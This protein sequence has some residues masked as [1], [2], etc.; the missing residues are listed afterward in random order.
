MGVT[1]FELALVR[2]ECAS[3][4][5]RTHRRAF[6]GDNTRYLLGPIL[7]G[8]FLLSSGVL[9]TPQSALH[10]PLLIWC[11]ISFHFTIVCSHLEIATGTVVV[12]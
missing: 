5:F 3:F 7:M 4:V 8:C 12:G 1:E 9:I 10:M 11:A 6:R 2:R